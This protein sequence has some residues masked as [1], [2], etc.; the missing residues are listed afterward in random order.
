MINIGG[1][2][3]SKMMIG[4]V[5]VYEATDPR[6]TWLELKNDGDGVTSFSGQLLMNYDENTGKT[7]MKGSRF[8]TT[9]TDLEKSLFFELPNGYAFDLSRCDKTIPMFSSSDGFNHKLYVAELSYSE[10]KCYV[11]ARSLNN[12]STFV[13]PWFPTDSFNNSMTFY[14]TKE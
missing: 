5:V 2:K 4:N 6:T 8:V 14:L 10:N 11:N 9:N 12:V 7:I 13:S 1:K 3:V